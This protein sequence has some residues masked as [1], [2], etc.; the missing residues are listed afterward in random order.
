MF[1]YISLAKIPTLGKVAEL[2]RYWRRRSCLA[3]SNPSPALPFFPPWEDPTSRKVD[4]SPHPQ[5]L[6]VCS[7]ALKYF[8]HEE[9]LSET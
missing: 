8:L 1:Q 6:C 2:L 5:R 3:R 4:L 9:D 7:E